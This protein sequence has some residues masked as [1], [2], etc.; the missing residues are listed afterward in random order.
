[1]E[2][3]R[4]WAQRWGRYEF[5]PPS[6]QTGSGYSRPSASLLDIIFALFALT[7]RNDDNVLVIES[8]DEIFPFRD[9]FESFMVGALGAG[10]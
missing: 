3:A 2:R 6:R 8:G 5:Q 9:G 10:K 7:P 1:M 4:L